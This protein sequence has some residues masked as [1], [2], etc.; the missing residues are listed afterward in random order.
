[1]VQEGSGHPLVNRNATR[2][3]K[4]VFISTEMCKVTITTSATVQIVVDLLHFTLLLRLPKW[5]GV[6]QYRWVRCQGRVKRSWEKRLPF[7]YFGT[8][9][10]WTQMSGPNELGIDDDAVDAPTPEIPAVYFLPRMKFGCK[11]CCGIRRDLA[12]ISVPLLRTATLSRLVSNS[13]SG[14]LSYHSLHF[15]PRGWELCGRPYLYSFLQ[16]EPSSLV[17]SDIHSV[18]FVTYKRDQIITSEVIRCQ[19]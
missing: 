15:W 6:P 19:E 12:S 9:C 4:S 5:W 16:H 14:S 2:A 8:F 10:L 11:I 7:W 18:Q 13:N 3:A 1:M 17:A